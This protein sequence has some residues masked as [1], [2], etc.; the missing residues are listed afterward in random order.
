MVFVAGK[1]AAL[2][3]ALS[4]AIACGDDAAP[5]TGTESDGSTGSPTSSPSTSASTSSPSTTDQPTTT[6]ETESSSSDESSSS[7]GEGELEVS[8]E[9]T[10]YEEQPMVVDVRLTTNLPVD[11]VSLVHT[12]DD[13]V[14]IDGGGE[15][16][17]Y[18]YRVRGLAPATLH[19]VEY[20]VDGLV[21]TEEFTTDAPLPGFVPAF[22]V[23]PNDAAPEAPYRM[24]DLIPFP[25]FN[26]AGVFM[27]DTEGTT[28]WHLGGPSNEMPGPEG[29]WTAAQ[30]RA[31]G[32]FMYLHLH[33]FFI[34]DELGQIITEY[35]DNDLGVTGLHHEILELPSGN[36]MALTHTFQEVDYGG[37]T[38]V[39]LTSGDG[40]V[41]FTPDGEVVWEWDTF[42][43]LDPMRTPVP[44]GGGVVLHP[45]TGESTFDW[46]HG[47]ALEY[48][49]ATD[50]LLFSM[51]HQDWILNI[52]HA[53]GDVLWTLG[54]EGDFAFEDGDEN[55][56]Y[57][58]HSPQWQPDGTLL[59]YDN[60]IG[61]PFVDPLL[62]ESR[63]LR[64]NVDTDTMTASIA[65]EDD[66]EPFQAAFA[67]D[68]DLLPESGRYIVTDSSVFNMMGMIYTRVRELDPE[69]SPMTTWA[70]FT[71][72]GSF[73]YR[74]TAQPRLVGMTAD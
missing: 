60:Q 6:G 40:I 9:I 42:D 34:R 46:T 71:P 50:T 38:G 59:L 36:F 73:A 19:A 10:Q 30:P 41:E 57:H 58:Q 33:T 23:E 70:L 21:G 65:W 55:W 54:Y 27:V 22:E 20:D 17:E 51:R 62:Y 69:A 56:F 11:T 31:D 61:N 37:K 49:E 1:R 28:R 43:H 52:D 44:V 18:N 26:T 64:L 45:E 14:V 4:T 32:T 7:S 66:A 29:V 39:V 25:A 67:G 53:T 2:L 5:S 72:S 35:T 74:A 3:A 48:D 63:A 15:G 68:S 47:N 8:V 24:F 16:M 13:G 12:T